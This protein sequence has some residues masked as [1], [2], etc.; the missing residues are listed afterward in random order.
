MKTFRAYRIHEENKKIVARFEDLSLDDLSPGDVVVRVTYSDINYKDA[1]A[2]TGAGRILR[3][4]PLV[5]GIDFAGVVES[6]ADARFHAGDD[7]LV[8]GCALSETHDGGYAQFARVPGDWLI[9]LP[10]GLDARGAMSLGTAGFTA[11]LAI[12]LMERNEQSP[13]GGP[14][15]V[16]GASGGVGSIAIDMLAARGYEVI[17]VSG[18]AA[19]VEYLKS[20]GAARVLLREA[21]DYGSKPLEAAQFGGAIDSVGGKTLAWLTRTVDF[22]GN[23]AS[24]GL[25]GGA[26]LETTVMPFILRGVNLLGINSSATPRALRLAV[27]QRIATDLAPRHLARIVTRTVAFADLPRAFAPLIDGSILGRTLVKID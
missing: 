17:A 12:H 3:R 9:P 23:I 5:G 22:R 15:V 24:I 20:L 13:R 21:V 4:Y 19:A 1:L 14:I 11:A 7:V 25:V 2:A 27:W 10:Q 8:T 18:K 16:T 6:S 26:Q